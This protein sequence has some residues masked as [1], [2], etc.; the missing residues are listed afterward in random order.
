MFLCRPL[1][2]VMAT[3]LCE[4]PWPVLTVLADRLG[5]AELCALRATCQRLREELWVNFKRR[6]W[7][8]HFKVAAAR[9]DVDGVRHVLA[10]PRFR[11]WAPVPLLLAAAAAGA[12]DALELASAA[13]VAWMDGLMAAGKPPEWRQRTAVDIQRAVT[14][15]MFAAKC[16]AEQLQAALAPF[17]PLHVEHILCQA[18]L[19][20]AGPVL[21]HFLGVAQ[22]GALTPDELERALSAAACISAQHKGHEHLLDICLPP[23]EDNIVVRLLEQLAFAGTVFF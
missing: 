13:T 21:E 3:T 12:R 4:L 17:G 2:T 20:N 14:S 19:H 15:R 8:V 22:A 5:Y 18:A 16:T 23:M 11:N 6:R 10:A 1:N 7:E 9:N